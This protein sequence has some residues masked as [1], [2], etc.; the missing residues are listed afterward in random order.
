MKLRVHALATALGLTVP[1]DLD[2]RCLAL[3]ALLLRHNARTNLVGDARLDAFVA[4]LHEAL[5][6]AAVARALLGRDPLRV[7]DVGAGAG[8]EALLFA[9][10]FPAAHVVAV[11]PRAK[12]AVFIELAADSVGARQ[13]HVIARPLAEARLVPDFD[14]VTSRAVWPPLQWLAQARPYAARDGV[15]LAHVA[16]GSPPLPGEAK[17]QDVP[18]AYEHSVVGVRVGAAAPKPVG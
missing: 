12:R 9:L 13:L 18:G 15:V 7:L 11:E 8:L 4:H 6:A 14:I 10:S 16:T 3:H 1:A 5:V 2:A 17:R